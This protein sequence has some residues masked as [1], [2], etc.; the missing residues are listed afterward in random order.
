VQ[1]LGLASA[2]D[3]ALPQASMNVVLATAP[4]AMARMS[5]CLLFM[6]VFTFFSSR[7]RSRWACRPGMVTCSTVGA[8]GRRHREC[9]E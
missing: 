3:P 1:S 7:L 5:L 4:A 6:V 2:F 8:F 9:F